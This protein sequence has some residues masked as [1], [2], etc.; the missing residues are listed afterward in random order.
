MAAGEDPN[1]EENSLFDEYAQAVDTP[2]NRVQKVL[3]W[4]F[5]ALFLLLIAFWV[6]DSIQSSAARK[7]KDPPKA[8]PQWIK[9]RVPDAVILSRSN[10]RQDRI[11]ERQKARQERREKR[12]ER[13]AQQVEQEQVTPTPTP[14][15]TQKS[16]SGGLPGLLI[17]IRAH[18]SGGNYSA[19]NGGGCE[20]YGCGGAYQLHARYASAWAAEAGFS[21]MPSNAAQWPP[22]TQDAVALYK[23]NQTN[24]GLW[25]DWVDY[26]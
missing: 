17:T 23:F 8:S 7:E 15:P 16:S 3:F 5:L 12:Q 9:D 4:S 22:A 1:P 19:Y 24:G 11:E 25:C 10:E 6:L 20:G 14:S 18:E 13:L 21:G 2:T 26:C